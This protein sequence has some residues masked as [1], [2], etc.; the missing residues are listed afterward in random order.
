MRPRSL[1]LLLSLLALLGIG[2]AVVARREARAD[3]PVT[4]DSPKAYEAYVEGRNA[5]FAL[6]FEAAAAKFDVALKEDPEFAFAHLALARARQRL[7]DREAAAAAFQRAYDLREGLGELERWEIEMSYAEFHLNFDELFATAK[8]LIKKYPEAPYALAT[9][10]H[11]A[12]MDRDFATAIESLERLLSVQPNHVACHRGLGEIYLWVGQ[13]DE[14]LNSLQRYVFYADEQAEPHQQLASAHMQLGHYDEAI[15]ELYRALELDPAFARAGQSLAEAYALTGQFD[16]ARKLLEHMEPVFDSA[17]ASRTRDLA[18]LEIAY[19][20]REWEQILELT[21]GL[22]PI[23][24]T[25]DKAGP[26]FPVVIYLF[27]SLANMELGRTQTAQAGIDSMQAH[28]TRL[29][30]LYPETADAR[31][32][33]RLLDGL[34]QSRLHR[35]QGMPASGIEQLRSA[36]DE[37]SFSPH[38]LAQYRVELARC[39]MFAGAYAEVAAQARAVLDYIP[40]YPDMLFLASKAYLK[41]DERDTARDLL[42]RY[43][44][45]MEDADSNHPDVVEALALW[46]RLAPNM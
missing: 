20:T 8:Q 13:Y 1:I 44:D 16:R 23:P 40:N 14:A 17:Q 2:A 28:I 45:Q 34:V 10:A 12:L 21:G 46:R 31:D 43:L 22:K 38:N 27:E 33:I 29:F 18:L 4:T 32:G 36:I 35:A 19:L 3:F 24:A 11:L 25:V 42:S 41:L 15:A 30:A 9:R 6:R 37:S 39:Y 7:D 5:A 26:N